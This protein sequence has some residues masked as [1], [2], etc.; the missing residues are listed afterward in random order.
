MKTEIGHAFEEGTNG[1]DSMD[2]LKRVFSGMSPAEIIKAVQDVGVSFSDVLSL[3]DAE[4][5]AEREK[6]EEARKAWEEKRAKIEEEIFGF[7]EQRLSVISGNPVPFLVRVYK[8]KDGKLVKRIVFSNPTRPKFRKGR[9]P[10][11]R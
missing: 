5:A 11:A 3:R 1:E 7:V 10:K 2:L 6:V 4:R 9:V 8:D